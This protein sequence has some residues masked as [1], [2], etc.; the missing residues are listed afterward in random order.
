MVLGWCWLL[1]VWR[2]GLSL[3]PWQHQAAGRAA[4]FGWGELEPAAVGFDEAAAD[5]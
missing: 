2:A 1:G 5:R 3:L 4:A